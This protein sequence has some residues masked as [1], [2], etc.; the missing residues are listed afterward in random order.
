MKCFWYTLR[1][2]RQRHAELRTHS[3]TFMQYNT[4][5]LIFHNRAQWLLLTLRTLWLRRRRRRAALAD[6]DHRQLRSA[7]EG[8][9]HRTPSMPDRVPAA[10]GIVLTSARNFSIHSRKC[11][12]LMYGPEEERLWGTAAVAPP[13]ADPVESMRR[14]RAEMDKRAPEWRRICEGLQKQLSVSDKIYK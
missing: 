9:K 5:K 8:T 13:E 7:N 10:M 12:R 4:I 2:A 3:L 1:L 11:S 14:R 6:D